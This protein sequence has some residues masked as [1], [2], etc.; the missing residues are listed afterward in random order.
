MFICIAQGI[1]DKDYKTMSRDPGIRY[2]GKGMIF[3][4]QR[5]R[6]KLLNTYLF[7]KISAIRCF[8]HLS[9]DLS[10]TEMLHG[11]YIIIS[12]R[13]YSKKAITR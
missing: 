8:L 3:A 2:S 5:E 11:L 4:S 10:V 6:Y 7:S 13:V 9:F 1:V 12:Q